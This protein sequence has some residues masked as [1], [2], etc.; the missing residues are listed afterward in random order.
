MKY[1]AK[2]IEL[3]ITGV[4]ILSFLLFVAAL[5]ASTDYAMRDA[6]IIYHYAFLG[7]G[8]LLYLLGHVMLNATDKMREAAE[9]FLVIDI[10]VAVTFLL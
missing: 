9:Q 7:V 3:I 4:Y 1:I 2:N 5:F 8:L 6:S 10:V